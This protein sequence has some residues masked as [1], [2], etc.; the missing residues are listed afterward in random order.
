MKTLLFDKLYSL[1]LI[2][3]FIS[4]AGNPWKCTEPVLLMLKNMEKRAVKM[5]GQPKC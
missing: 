1:I 3:S 2:F 5:I 4:F